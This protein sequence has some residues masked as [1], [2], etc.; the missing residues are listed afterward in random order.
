MALDAMPSAWGANPANLLPVPGYQFWQGKYLVDEC[1]YSGRDEM[2]KSGPLAKVW[3]TVVDIVERIQ[4]AH[5]APLA[6]A[7]SNVAAASAS[8]RYPEN[9]VRHVVPNKRQQV[10]YTAI[11]SAFVLPFTHAVFSP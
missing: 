6:A 2:V 5:M 3:D 4:K 9:D 8:G 7:R 1:L 10:Y 11:S